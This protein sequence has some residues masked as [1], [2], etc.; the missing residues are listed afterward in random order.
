[1]N[2]RKTL[3]RKVTLYDRLII[4][5]EKTLIDRLRKYFSA[6]FDTFSSPSA[7]TLF[8][9]ILSILA[10]ESAHSIVFLSGITKKSLNTFIMCVPMRK[11]ITPDL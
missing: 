3:Q 9:F 4:Y 8:L 11:L 5:N 10:L 7:E 2:L 6:Y 1:M